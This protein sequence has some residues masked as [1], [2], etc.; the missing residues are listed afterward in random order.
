MKARKTTKS[1]LEN[2]TAIFFEIGLIFALGVVYFAFNAKSYQKQSLNLLQQKT[3]QTIQ[4]SVPVTV[5]KEK[6]PPPPPKQV[7]QIKIVSNSMKINENI[8]IDVGALQSTPVTN[9]ASPTE[10]EVPEK[11]IFQVVEDMPHFKG[12][13]VALMKYLSAHIQYP[14]MA[15]EIGVQG[16]VF[17][18]FVVEPD[19]SI[20]QVEIIR[21]I[22][23]G[24]DKEAMRVVK[25]MPKWVPGKQRGKP[26]RVF[27][28]IPVKFI[29]Q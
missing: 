27:F 15:K 17:V 19:G 8:D 10:E 11:T 16:T 28:N 26:V 1:D 18:K 7:T 5:Q 3:Q 12:G 13:E 21:G 2:K 4:E 6:L 23:G 20:D 24:C 29:L 14:E 25:S 22:G 9:Y